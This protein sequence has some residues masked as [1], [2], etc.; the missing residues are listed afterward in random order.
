MARTTKT[1][2]LIPEIF[3]EAVQGAF[4]QKDAFRGSNLVRTGAAV[5]SGEFPGGPTSIGNE[6]EVPYFSLLGDFVSN[7]DGSAVSPAKLGQTGEKATVSRDS[8]AF[9]VTRWAQSSKGG[10]A[11]EESAR[12]IVM[13]AERAIDKRCIDAATAAGGLRT[14]VYNAGAPV[15][16]TYDLV[17]DAKSMWGD[18]QDDVAAMI[19]TSR[20]LA[21]LYKMKDLNGLPLLTRAV[22]GGLP[23]FLGMPVVVSDRM[24]VTGSGM[25]SVTSAGTTPPTVTLSGTPSGPWKL[26][27]IITVGGTLGVAKFKFSTDG[28]QNYS[29]EFTTAA[30]VP[31]LDTAIDSLIGINGAT[32]ITAAFAAGTYNVDNVY[33][34]TASPKARTLLV[35]KGALAFWYNRAGLQLQTDRDILADSGIGAMHLYAAAI[36]YRRRP[37]SVRPGVVEIA[38]NVTV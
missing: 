38:H 31:L 9:E 1:D 21:D 25:G 12:Q 24:P 20:A 17:V 2:V 10:D 19:V 26:R 28:G 35:K 34:A 29:A 4:A 7:P 22:D 36:R 3:T 18:D 15:Y 5:V 11:Y 14:D 30:S 6:V 13:A 8:L 32:G 23:S 16:L 27:I 33:T 37:G